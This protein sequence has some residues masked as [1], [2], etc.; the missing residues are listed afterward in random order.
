MKKSSKKIYTRKRPAHPDEAHTASKRWF[1]RKGRK[2][3]RKHLKQELENEKSNTDNPV[4][5]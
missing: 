2:A 5:D 1:K 4:R 3:V